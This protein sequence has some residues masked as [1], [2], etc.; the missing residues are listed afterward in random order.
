MEENEG[1]EKKK[2]TCKE[3]IKTQ[4]LWG[5]VLHPNFLCLL[6]MYLTIGSIL[7]L[8]G[9]V[10]LGVTLNINDLE[11]RYDDT[12]GSSSSCTVT[13]VPSETLKK[14]KV[15]YKISNFYGNHRKYV[16]SMDYSQLRADSSAAGSK[17]SPIKKNK[18][19][20]SSLLAV[21]G[22]TTLDPNSDANPCGLRA[23][24]IFTDSFVLTKTGGGTIAIDETKISH[25]IDRSSKFKHPSDYLTKQWK[26]T[27][28]EH[29]MV[30]YQVDA[31]SNFIKLWG[32]IDQNL[33]AGTNYTIT[34]TNS[35]LNQDINS[36][37]VFFSETN[38]LGGKNLTLGIMYLVA[39]I[40]F[41]L[42][43]VVAVF[44]EI[45][46]QREQTKIIKDY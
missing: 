45:I 30:W 20:S 42:F 27:E 40:V 17:C 23:K 5:V 10:M 18:D 46:K 31:F 15:Y 28:D 12:C 4:Q 14:P 6:L 1:K 13:F 19:I 43:A 35:Y 44:L 37:A 33:E 38:F 26:D 11:L 8:F 9:G 25:S 24:Y 36:K 21:D 3:N 29:L 39:G 34:I 7:I 16:K 41:I 32:K 2:H 22:T